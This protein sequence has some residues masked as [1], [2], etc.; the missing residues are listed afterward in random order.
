MINKFNLE[1]IVEQLSNENTINI[2][3]SFISIYTNVETR[4]NENQKYV[5]I[6]ITQNRKYH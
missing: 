4:T 6:V 2:H 5:L 3:A 1:L